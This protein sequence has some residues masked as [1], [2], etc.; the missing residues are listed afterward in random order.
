MNNGISFQCMR[1]LNCCTPEHFGAETAYIPLYLDEVDRIRELAAQKKLEIQVEPDLM[2]YDELN[3]RLIIATYTLQLGKEGCPFHRAGCTI[4]EHRP[5]TCKA[6]PLLVH[7]IG[8]TT[9]IMLK[10][11]CKFIS[12]NSQKL[13]DLDYYDVSDVFCDEFKFAREIQIKGYGITS[14]ILELENEKKI[15][16]PV[17]IPVEITAETEEMDKVRLDEIKK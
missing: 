8:D 14:K 7:R 13:E 6:Y 5:I 2:Y 1:C 15:R 10:P 17:K 4:H 11:E 12:E 9:G 16:V 3:N